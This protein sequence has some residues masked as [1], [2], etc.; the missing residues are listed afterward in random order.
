MGWKVLKELLIFEGHAE[1]K[2]GSPRE[3]IKLAF[4]MYD[5][6]DEE[7]WLAML[8][9]RNST[10]HIYD[11]EAA[12]ELVHHILDRYIPIF[13]NMREEVKDQYGGWLE[14]L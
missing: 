14:K 6:I 5:F 13:V 2:S 4:T 3:I 1:A 10:A 9:E 11:A 8:R 7:I 12:L